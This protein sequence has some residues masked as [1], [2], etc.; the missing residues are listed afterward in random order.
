MRI[1]YKFASRSRPAKF[2]SCLDNIIQ[3]A[4]HSDYYILCS[5]D[6]DDETMNNK[7]VTDRLKAYSKHVIVQWGFSKNKIDAINRDVTASLQWDILC[8]HSDDMWFVKPGFD[9][10]IIE[11]FTNFSGLVHFPDQ[12]AKNLLCTYTMMSYDYYLQD[13]FVYHPDFDSVYA[14]NFQQDIAKSRNAYKFVNKLILEHRHPMWGFGEPDELL[15]K[16][17]NKA[18]YNKDR[19]TYIKLKKEWN[20]S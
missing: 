19:E 13:G 20:L 6:S 2:F 15:L 10:D 18:T 7:E 9:L 14:D 1:L 3:N 5:L 12:Q 16:T 17:E 11:A 8:N 4:L